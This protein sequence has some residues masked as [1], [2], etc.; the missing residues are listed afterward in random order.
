MKKIAQIISRLFDPIIEGPFLIWLTTQLVE[1]DLAWKK[2]FLISLFFIYLLPLVFFLLSLK[3]GWISDLDTTKR[4]E[5]YGIYSFTLF[6]IVI[7]L[8][9]FY[10]LNEKM[11]F[12]FY[13]KLFLPVFIFFLITFFWKISGHALM[14][15]LFI[16]LLYFYSNESS[17]LYWGIFLIILVGWSRVFLK[18]HTWVQV[19]AGSLLPLL[20]IIKN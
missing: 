6:S 7:C 20:I 3:R 13:L 8:L 4:K 10:F 18:K 19:I 1:T 14:N 12:F 2:V 9:V 16:L 11:I 15:S 17:I 5:R